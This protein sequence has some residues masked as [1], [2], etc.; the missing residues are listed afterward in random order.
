[1]KH[2]TNLPAMI[3][4]GGSLARP[5]A[6]AQ[7]RRAW[8][9]VA[10]ALGV[11]A[12]AVAAA[13]HGV[14]RVRFFHYGTE[15]GL[16]QTTARVLLQ[17]SRGFLW[18]GTQD[19]LNRFDGYEFR[20]Y[21]HE[22]DEPDS[23][24]DNHI[25]A[26]AED[27]EGQVWVG[28][29]AGGLARMDVVRDRFETWRHRPDSDGGLAGNPVTAVMVDRDGRVWVASGAGF[30]QWTDAKGAFRHVPRDGDVTLGGIRVLRQRANGEVVVGARQGL[31]IVSPDGTAWREL[32][33]EPAVALDAYDVA[34]TRDGDLWV[35]TAD[36]G[37]QRFGADGVL[38][39][40]ITRRDGLA[41]DATRAILQDRAG[42]IW[43]GTFEGLSRIDGDG[44]PVRTWRTD[45]AVRD[46]LASNRVQAL[47]EDRDGQVW[48]GTWFSGLDVFN[49]R[50]EAFVAIRPQHDDPLSLPGW[51]VPAMLA[52]A[53][54]TLWF[55]VME[56]GGLVH[57]D[58]ATG[59][60]R[61]WTHDP[62]VAGSLSN[63][64]VQ[65]IVRDR[66]GRLWIGTVGGGVN[67]LREDG[68]F[69]HFRHDATDPGSLASDTV[70]RMY[71][72]SAN[73]LWVG[74][75]EAGLSALCDGCSEFRH[76]AGSGE[77]QDSLLDQPVTSM[78]EDHKG[79]FWI[80]QRPGGLVRLDRATGRFERWHGDASVPGALSN[81]SISALF[82]DSEDRLW[83]GT[84]GG[85]LN[86]LDEAADGKLRF[87]AWTRRDGLAGDAI[88]GIVEDGNGI[89]W[90][91]T[92][93]GISRLDPETARVQS[94]GLRDGVQQ[95]GY[96]IGSRASLKD[97][98][99]AFGGLLGVT[100]F[101]PAL[102]RTTVPVPTVAI[103]N[104]Q[105]TRGA[106]AARDAVEVR[107][108]E[109]RLAGASMG[110][111]NDDLTV[112]FSALSFS[113]P[114][115]VSYAFRLDG[116]DRGWIATDARRRIASYTDLPAGDY[117]F[118]VRARLP[119][120]DW[121]PETPIGITIA[122]PA[123]ATRRALLVYGVTAL[124]LAAAFAWLMRQRSLERA[125]A[126]RHLRESESRLKT[127]L[128]GTGDELW[129]IDLVTRE[130]RRENPLAHIA[131]AR[132]PYMPDYMTLA[133]AMHP[134]DLPVFQRALVA[135]LKG[136][137]A[138][139]DVLY[140]MRD[141]QGDWRWLR[142]RARATRHDESGRAARLTGTTSDVTDLKAH[143]EAL[144]RINQDLERRVRDR[145]TDLSVVND[146][147]RRTIDELQQAQKQLVESEKMAAL[148][149][150]VAGVAH[151]INTP[152]GVGVTA[153]SH[154]EIETQ[155]LM[156][157]LD[158]NTLARSD[159][160]A[161]QRIAADSAQL[162]LRNLQRADKLVKSFKQVAVDQSSEQRRRIDLRTYLDE[163][164]T[165][166]HPAIK[167][168][169]HV[170]E[171]E[172]P[173]DL[174]FETY[175]GAIYQIMV[176]LVMNSLIHGFEGM[177]QGHIRI[178]AARRGDD[179]V[180]EYTDDG[181]GMLE[182]VRRR[183]FEP[184][185]TT[186]RGQ[187]GSGLGLHICYNLTTQVLRGTIGVESAPGRGVTFV[188]RFPITSAPAAGTSTRTETANAR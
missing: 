42:R 99:I 148:G 68:T 170:V 47:I 67:L 90:L 53:D 91:S 71:V 186:R 9:P 132:D 21:R 115:V 119:G 51:P 12:G 72:D 175:P 143:E 60:I 104:L 122:P 27:A 105:G 23:V 159:L 70:H 162:I 29:Q 180:L 106:G 102:V 149:S 82:E 85:G 56:G 37:V 58:L 171:V 64:V 74:T 129:E 110:T 103:T 155:R 116:E 178:A 62:A 124:L 25:T 17:D 140:R 183:V 164:L 75:L 69:Q 26:L 108:Y 11:A 142:S 150:L 24:G 151:E 2:D 147:L 5:P 101:D 125:S 16:S 157:K 87:Q 166:L 176:N 181:R 112:E 152:L 59:L 130:L 94:F 154:L 83:I 3:P 174:E 168:T 46:G 123:W 84:Q 126:D 114:A 177:D 173:A 20:V 78:L 31:W 8:W 89:L 188:I 36:T 169:R 34:E 7:R 52:D 136:E 38:R 160:D 96:F 97:G 172:C 187:G 144:E 43:I 109:G 57:F 40:S 18:V 44:S 35:A 54:G 182:D 117:Q 184:F 153:A 66:R 156:R 141:T 76:Y 131:A 14:E 121:G 41:D 139:F 61:R 55:G 6:A 50:T 163:I 73:T 28:T 185:F 15:D 100:V 22:A 134:D 128:W 133:A 86:R 146:S 167:K 145:T 79:R 98:R 158:S 48:I 10:L 127:T 179:L 113:D 33:G 63:N 39:G 111:G 65:D 93:S 1:M 107:S 120:G 161:F 138:H 32:R 30:L 77:G 118:R 13:E 19:G 45:L 80:G 135:H 88:G 92:V 165:S 4:S 137:E 49:P 81:D 95:R